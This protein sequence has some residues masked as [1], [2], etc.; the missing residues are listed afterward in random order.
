MSMMNTPVVIV[1]SILTVVLA[2]LGC[3][4]GKKIAEK[5]LAKGGST[6]ERK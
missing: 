2:F 1:L 4:W 6:G 5:R 3:L